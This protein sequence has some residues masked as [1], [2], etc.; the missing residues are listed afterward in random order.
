MDNN[1]ASTDKD[2]N[3]ASTDKDINEDLFDKDSNEDLAR[4]IR[5]AMKPCLI[6]QRMMQGIISGNIL[7]QSQDSKH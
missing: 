1:K 2:N 3:E 4:L 7:L 6:S 5:I